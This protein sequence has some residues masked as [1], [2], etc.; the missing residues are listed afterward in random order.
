MSS[1]RPGSAPHWSGPRLPLGPR[2]APPEGCIRA[3]D[4]GLRHDAPIGFDL[5]RRGHKV[6]Q[7]QLCG[8][9]FRAVAQLQ[10]ADPLTVY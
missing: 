7:I 9:C 6:G 4:P 8:S 5:T 1:R 3:G 2:S 10:S